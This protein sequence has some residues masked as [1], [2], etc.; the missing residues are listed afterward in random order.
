[1]C[2]L[3]RGAI[4]TPVDEALPSGTVTFVLTDVVSST[5]LWQDAP[6]EMDAAIRRHVEVIA[7]AVVAR[8]GTVLKSR[9]EGDS[10]F[11]VFGRATDAVVAAHDAQVALRRERWPGGVPLSVRLAVHTGEA[12]ERDGDYLGPVV[13]RAARLR[14]IAGEA[15]CSSVAPPQPW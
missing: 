1:M 8:G 2:D 7:T 9:G 12:V 15:R 5:R 11:C 10:T 4:I 13:N 3:E 6:E 14:S